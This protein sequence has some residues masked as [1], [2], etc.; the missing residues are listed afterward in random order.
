MVGSAHPTIFAII[1]LVQDLM[2]GSNWVSLGSTQPII[3]E[4][5]R[6]IVHIYHIAFPPEKN[7]KI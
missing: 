7:N 2:K 5:L 6:L 4:N 1:N 3:Y